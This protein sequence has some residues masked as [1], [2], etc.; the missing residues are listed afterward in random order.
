MSK[1][2]NAIL[3]SLFAFVGLGGIGHFYLNRFKEGFIFL[4]GGIILE[5]LIFGIIMFASAWVESGFDFETLSIIIYVLT[6]MVIFI[7]SLIRIIFI[8]RKE[9]NP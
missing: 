9:I 8:K 3:F 6:G 2:S 7:I 4:I 5:L 1:S